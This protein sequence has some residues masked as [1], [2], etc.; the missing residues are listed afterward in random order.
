MGISA[1]MAERAIG[2]MLPG[3]KFAI[4]IPVPDMTAFL[5]HIIPTTSAM[6]GGVLFTHAET[7]ATI[8]PDDPGK[9]ISADLS[10]IF[11]ED[12]NYSAD[13]GLYAELIQNRSFE[14]TALDN[15]AW[16]S[17]T[18]WKLEQRDGGEGLWLFEVMEPLHADNPHYVILR[19]TEPGGGVGLCNEGFDGI[20]VKAGERY[21]VSFFA[22]QLYMNEGYGEAIAIDHISLFPEKTFQGRR[23]GLRDDL[24]RMIADLHPTFMRF[25]G[26]CVAHGMG[27]HNIYRWKDTIGP[28]EQ[29][30][31]TEEPPPQAEVTA[32]SGDPQVENPI[33]AA[34]RVT[35]A[36]SRLPLATDT[37]Y[38]SPQVR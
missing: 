7:T 30:R 24:A 22:R 18:S 3:L 21:D 10:G 13:G 1:A 17:F 34:P 5:R 25:P 6:F 36:T 15:V 14:Y 19:V 31:G 29:R 9:P 11:F 33:D 20:P 37:S 8:R 28:L 23:N 35:P 32:I 4:K 12:I 2:P 27:L 26:G 16:S 38:E